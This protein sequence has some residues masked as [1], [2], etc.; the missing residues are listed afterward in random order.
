MIRSGPPDPPSIFIGNATTGAP[1]DRQP[2]HVGNILECGCPLF[3]QDHMALKS[4]RLSVVDAGGIEADR[5]DGT[6]FRQPSR[7]LGI[8]PRKVQVRHCCGA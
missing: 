6:M 3:K 2:T 1:E 4:L 8:K 5:F 7:S